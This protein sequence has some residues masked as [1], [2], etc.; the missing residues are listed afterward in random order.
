M[1]CI[2]RVK[3]KRGAIWLQWWRWC[4]QYKCPFWSGVCNHKTKNSPCTVKY[5]IKPLQLIRKMWV[6][7]IHETSFW[8]HSVTQ[9]VSQSEQPV[10]KKRLFFVPIQRWGCS[11]AFFT[12]QFFVFEF[13]YFAKT[14]EL[15]LLYFSVLKSDK[16]LFCAT[17]QNRIFLK[18]G[19]Q[20]KK[21]HSFMTMEEY[22]C[23]TYFKYFVICRK[24]NCRF[25][26]NGYKIILVTWSDP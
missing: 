24:N 2:N 19:H 18:R 10:T 9:S 14:L 11:S 13:F 15:L 20:V 5:Y 8:T 1:F 22:C 17:K 12:P 23:S 6:C 3:G 7:E 26:A 4:N 16:D 25:M 21:T